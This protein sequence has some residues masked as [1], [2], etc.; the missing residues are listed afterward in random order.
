MRARV[1]VVAGSAITA[2]LVAGLLLMYLLQ[3]NSV[4]STIDGQLRTYAVQIEQAGES[5]TWPR[6]LPPSTID[7]NAAAQVTD[8]EGHVLAATATLSGD[9]ALYR[10]APGSDT[11]TRLPAAD[12]RLPGEVRVYGT[13]ATVAGQPV[14]IITGTGTGLLNQVNEQSAHALLFGTP[15]LLL[16][17]GVT[18][19][20]ITGRALRPVEQIRHAVTE[21]TSASL[22]RRV[23]EPGTDDEIGHLAVTMND[24]L[25]RLDESA[26]RQRRFVADA[27][28]EL[29]SPLAAIRTTLEVGLA[30]PDAAPWPTIAQRAVE[31]ARR[32]EDLTQQLLALA[33]TDDRQLAA[34]ARPVEITRLLDDIRATSTTTAT[35]TTAGDAPIAI[36]VTA[37]PGSIVGDPNHLER[38]F[39]NIIDNAVRYA[40]SVVDV[41]GE[42]EEDRIRVLIDDDGP[43]IPVEDRERVFNRFVRLDESRDRHTGNAGLGLAIAREIVAAHHGRIAISESPQGGT[44]VTVE[45]PREQAGTD[46]PRGGDDQPRLVPY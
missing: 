30:H 18:V 10:L 1:T 13:R 46:A 12:G 41:T 15:V 21:I 14:S 33:K 43:G 4:R 36:A 8:A 11:P 22:T 6:P 5:G 25:A 32:L 37:A 28:H 2:G 19:W 44:R 3:M 38:M 16:L 27:S 26:Q 34:R 35:S 17:A 45:L 42:A 20:L 9:P 29:R 39:R 24:M 7:P 31:Q 23:P 40:H